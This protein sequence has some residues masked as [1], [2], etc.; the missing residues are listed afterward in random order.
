MELSSIWLALP[1]PMDTINPLPSVPMPGM[2]VSV[3]SARSSGAAS[4]VELAVTELL[5]AYCITGGCD[6]SEMR[7]QL[8]DEGT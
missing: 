2:K 7:V 4:K 3:L 5:A 8:R 1:P 6:A